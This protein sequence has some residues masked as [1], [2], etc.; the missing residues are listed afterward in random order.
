MSRAFNAFFVWLFGVTGWRVVGALP[1][2]G[3]YVLAGASHTSNWDFIVFLGVVHEMGVK[4]RYM[5]KHSLFRWPMRRFML[6]MGGIPVDRSKRANM[7]QQVVERIHAE[8]DF[9][10]VVAVEGT[11]SPTTEWKSGFYRIALAAGIPI[12]CVGPDYDRKL[13]IIGPVIQP[14]GDYE[15]DMQVA[16]DFYKQLKPAHPEKALFPDGSGISDQRLDITDYPVCK[17]RNR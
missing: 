12:V 10:L 5:G 7:V 15:A 11:R 14:T 2:G 6:D 16:I 9:A 8:D 1:P 4:P 17:G 3:K 13:G